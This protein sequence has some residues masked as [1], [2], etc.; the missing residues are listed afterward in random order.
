MKHG[1]AVISMLHHWKSSQKLS[2]IRLLVKGDCD[3]QLLMLIESRQPRWRSTSPGDLFLVHYISESHS[4]SLSLRQHI[5]WLLCLIN[6]QY[7]G[8]L[9]QYWKASRGALFKA[10]S[11]VNW[12]KALHRKLVS[13]H[14][15]TS[16]VERHYEK[17]QLLS[18]TERH[19][20]KVGQLS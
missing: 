19:M 12:R 4:V 3:G 5:S 8:Y 17:D 18:I 13:C 14:K 7:F 6:H 16:T 2:T 10:Y 11:I 15:Y 9:S 1:S 20:R